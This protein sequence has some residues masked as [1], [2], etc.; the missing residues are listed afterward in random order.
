MRGV[1][2]IKYNDYVTKSPRVS[3]DDMIQK[4]SD[5]VLSLSFSSTEHTDVLKK[6]LSRTFLRTFEIPMCGGIQLCRYYPELASYFEDGKEIVLY[7]DDKELVEKTRFYL[8]KAT[9]QNIRE[10]KEAARKR[11]EAEHTW[12][13]RFKIAFDKLGL[14]Y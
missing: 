11:A 8:N 4:Y 14:K 7:H 12:M 6:P 10:I 2:E 3:F 9:D 5:H 13:N 1:E